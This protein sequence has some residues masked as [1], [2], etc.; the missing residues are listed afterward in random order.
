MEV[1]L[2]RDG[3]G[4]GGSAGAILPQKPVETGSG[5]DGP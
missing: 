5:S 1:R 3:E 4:G 2:I